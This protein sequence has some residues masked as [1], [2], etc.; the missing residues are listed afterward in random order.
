MIVLTDQPCASP[1]CVPFR[2]VVAA[3]MT[4]TANRFIDG[5]D[6]ARHE[7]D[8]NITLPDSERCG[9]TSSDRTSVGEVQNYF[10]DSAQV[11]DEAR[12]AAM[13]KQLADI[14]ARALPA[15]YS[16]SDR[17]DV[18]PGPSTFFAM[19]NY[20]HIRVTFNTTPGS[21]QNRVTLL[22]GP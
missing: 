21:A 6:E 7:W 19:D 1:F 8:S 2:Q 12:G 3:V 18:R 17:S 22:V 11:A 14:V 9:L 13:A 20:P 5:W 16:R 10:C 15:A 4:D